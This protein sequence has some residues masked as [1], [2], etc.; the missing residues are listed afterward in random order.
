MS[1]TLNSRV[2]SAPGGD[3]CRP[4]VRPALTCPRLGS[5][6]NR[7]AGA[8]VS[9][10]AFA[11]RSLALL[12][13]LGAC[14]AL[15]GCDARESGNGI[16]A[17]RRISVAGFTALDVKD[18]VGAVVTLAPGLAQS[19]TLTGDENIVENNLQW[20]V[21]VEG[22]GTAAVSVLRV[23]A[24]PSFVPVIPARV[25]INRP[26]LARVRGSDGVV[27]QVARPAGS[28]A[29]GGPLAVELQEAT[30]SAREYPV[31]SAAVDL[32]DG[33][34][35]LLHSEGPVTGTVSADSRLD[36][37][38]GGGPCLVT[39]TAAGSVTCN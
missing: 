34:T 29:V 14:V 13:W 38:Y 30:L 31:S 5:P 28:T 20:R 16:Y 8:R 22:V 39:T 7:G 27:I 4:E 24:S 32:R 1:L 26:T 17:E 15:A 37:T 25:V 18:G 12:V 11:G 10:K 19:V 33:A 35:A 21:D 6:S 9:R 23:W 36:N 2:V 3:V